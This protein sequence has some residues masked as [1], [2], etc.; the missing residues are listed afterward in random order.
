M[1]TKKI[2]TRKCIGCYKSFP[3]REL[4]RIV[5]TPSGEVMVDL[6]GKANGR[7]AYICSLKCFEIIIKKKKLG[8]ALK[9]DLDEKTIENLSDKLLRIFKKEE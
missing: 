1:F 6:T 4:T 8:N 3:K 7:G 2:P 5:R 9:V